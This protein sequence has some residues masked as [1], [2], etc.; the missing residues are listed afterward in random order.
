VKIIK[1][2]T[3][4][5][6]TRPFEFRREFWLGVSVIA[7]LPIDDAPVLLPEAEL[8]PFLAEELPP[9]QALDAAIP[10]QQAEFLAIARAHAPNGE[11]VQ[12]LQTSIQLGPITKTLNVFGDRTYRG[13]EV[14][15]TL[16]F[17]QMPIDWAHAYGGPDVPANPKG[18]G[19]A[20]LDGPGGR[21][22]AA[23]NILD[24]QL[25]AEALRT[26]VSYGPVDQMAP[27]RLQ[28]AGTHDKTWLQEDF[29]GFARDID[30][31]FFNL[32]SPDQFFPGP[33]TG[34]EPYVFRNLHP[35]KPVLQG[36][37]PGMQAR[38]F[39]VR[40][41]APD[42]FEEIPMRLST[43]WCFPHRERL[44]LVHHGQTRLRE[45][46]GADIARI[47][48][49]ADR[50]GEHRTAQI[51]HDV[52]VCRA[53]TKEGAI[54][55][56]L[57][58][59]L[60]PADWLRPAPAEDEAAAEDNPKAI[61]AARQQQAA[62]AAYGKMVAGLVAKG[63]DPGK[64]PALP[65]P[66][67]YKVPSL[68]E[69]PQLMRQAREQQAAAEA[70]RAEQQEKLAGRLAAAGKAPA[71]IEALL[72]AQVNGPPVF[73][74]ADILGKLAAVPAAPGAAA[75]P[76]PAGLEAK[77]ADAEQHLRDGYRRMAHQQAPADAASTE[78]SA[79]IRRLVQGDSAAARALY[80]LQGADLSGLDLSGIDLSGVCL[81]GANL[82]G[83]NFSQAKLINTVLAHA[84]LAGARFDGA[85][86]TGATFGKANL[87]GA[88]L[89][90]AV[91]KKSVLAGANLS[92]ADFTG[93]DLEKADL[94]D[95]L[96][97]RTILADVRA[98]GLLAMKLNLRG[99]QAPGIMLDK[100]RFLECDLT[101][102]DFSGASLR[103]VMFLA[104]K[105]TAMRFVKTCLM[106]AVFVKGCNLS[107]ADFA[108][109]DLREVNLR[110][111]ILRNALLPGAN[112]QKADFSGA[113]L[114]QA[115]LPNVRG[116]DCGFVATLLRNADLRHG[117]F[118]RANFSRADLRGADLTS[119]S[120]YEAN[121]PRVQLDANTRRAGLWQT[122]MRYLPVYEPPKE[123]QA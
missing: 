85:E 56:L 3:L 106:Q 89:R 16:P 34:S 98:P 111:M 96:V 74:P 88:M 33:L 35:S 55:A 60:V 18:L 12:S 70:M 47:V 94:S 110:E 76:V 26:P 66:Q 83:T 27:A 99:L 9:D 10:K 53:D 32:A 15:A 28:R 43:I 69:L 105:M 73:K 57:D 86:L 22:F 52:M 84:N 121:M 61:L 102:A 21:L 87:T 41:G 23:P 46:D 119:A 38:V 19:A 117:S 25:G 81:D 95:A 29:P 49:G 118:A 4:G 92:Q 116:D 108:D 72:K 120:V 114:T 59:E 103:K 112:L 13:G 1:P 14:S 48:V 50:P 45:E 82:A 67:K 36:S 122:R 30:W 65:E 5:L 40:Q 39:V 37:L 104:C 51:F 20:P 17:T 101:G 77:L 6:L 42:G 123:P 91:L 78:R 62:A 80:D 64:I 8:W 97:F 90:R 7:F 79:E 24:P 71:E 93:A 75:P 63:V 107:F 11:K 115:M 100:A 44:V 109:A 2:T 68:S 31:R 58:E 113:D 54:H